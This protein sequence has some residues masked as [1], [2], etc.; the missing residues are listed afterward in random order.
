MSTDAGL[1]HHVECGLPGR[2]RLLA[3]PGTTLVETG[4]HRDLRTTLRALPA[5]AEVAVTGR[6]GVRRAARR[7]GVRIHAEYLALPSIQEPVVMVGLGEPALTYTARSVL[8]VPP[9]ITT[10]HLPVWSAVRLLRAFPRLLGWL[11]VG[12]RVVLGTW[13]P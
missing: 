4:R 5:G 10:L 9:G 3:A 13:T 11:P 8:T 7:A 2:W 6:L 1:G 12:D